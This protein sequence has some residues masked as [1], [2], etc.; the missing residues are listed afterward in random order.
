MAC[1]LYLQSWE[2]LGQDLTFWRIALGSFLASGVG[3]A[4]ESLPLAEVD[5][6]TVP[7]AAA[8]TARL[9]FGY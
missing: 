9:Y 6:W 2:L 8:V 7:V 4:V 1:L 5:N 3:S